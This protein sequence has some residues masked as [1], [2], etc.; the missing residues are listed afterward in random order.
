ITPANPLDILANGSAAFGQILFTAVIAVDSF[1]FL[2]GLMVVFFWFKTFKSRPRQTNS[3]RG[4][5]MFYVH[6]IW[7]LTPPLLINV[8]FYTYIFKQLLLD[9]PYNLVEYAWW[10]K[11]S[12]T[13]WWDVL[14]VHNY[15]EHA[16]V[17][18]GYSWYL[19]TEMQIYLF[20]P[21]LLIPMALKPVLAI[22]FGS[23]IMI[24]STGLNMF[25]VFHF[26][27]PVRH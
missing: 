15:V 23:L 7:R 22:T 27:W 17:C 18:T 14:Y 19:S 20:T 6:R 8:L 16:Y 21:L 5:I 24:I 9:T 11:C 13:W 26:D 2:S 10:D 4:W 12:W 25:M 3:V 1:F